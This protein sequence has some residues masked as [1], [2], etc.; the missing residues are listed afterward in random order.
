MLRAGIGYLR[1][2]FAFCCFVFLFFF[3]APPPLYASCPAA[4]VRKAGVICAVHE[5][6]RSSFS[7]EILIE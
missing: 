5:I 6:P 2:V 3:S 4:E 1:V 7:R